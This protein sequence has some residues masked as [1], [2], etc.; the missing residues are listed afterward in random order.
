MKKLTTEIIALCDYALVA[1]NNKPSIIGIF[2]E[3]GVQQF[4]GGMFQAILFATVVGAEGNS[5]HKL[6]FKA[7]SEKG[8]EPFPPTELE[9]IFGSSGR[10]NITLNIS[11]FVFPE[12]GEYKF[13]I[14]NGKEEVGSTTLQVFQAKQN[15][16]T[17][18]YEKN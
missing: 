17:Y 1:Q 10:S 8:K 13:S 3:L 6:T 5:N 2:T 15:E 11:N 7:V 12:P 18:S 9:A 16:Q 4:P 14:Y